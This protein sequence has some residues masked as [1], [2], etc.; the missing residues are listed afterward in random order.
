MSFLCSNLGISGI[1]LFSLHRPTGPVFYFYICYI[2][3][4]YSI[5]EGYT[6][7][8]LKLLNARPFEANLISIFWPWVPGKKGAG[9]NW[10]GQIK[11]RAFWGRVI[12]CNSLLIVLQNIL[13]NL[14]GGGS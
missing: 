1:K 7:L 4:W 2:F 14:G 8:A 10:A 9:Q 13:Y 11:G 6:L 12:F 5:V 3:I